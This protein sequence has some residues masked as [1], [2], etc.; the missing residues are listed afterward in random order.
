VSTARDWSRWLAAVTGVVMSL[1]RMAS[2]DYLVG[3]VAAGDGRE[4]STGSALTRYYAA[5]GYPP[6]TWLGTGLT[7]LGVGE[8]VG[9]E[10]TEEQ[11]RALFEDARSPF[12]GTP[13]GRPP[14]TYPTRQERIA[15]R[16]GALPE[17]MTAQDRAATVEKILAEEQDTKT[18][19]AVAG[20]D[21]TFSVPKSVSALWALGDHPL[22][23][24]LYLAHRAA[25]TAT[26][27]LV[28]A[29]ALFTRTGARGARRVRTGGMIAAA[30]DHWDSRKGDPQLHTH[31]TVANRVQGPDG[32][33]RTLDSAVLHRAVVAYSETYN[34]LLADEVTRR[35]GLGWELRERGGRGRRPARELAGVSD[36]LIAAFSQRSA[37]IEAAV[38]TAIDRTVQT[39]GRHPS[40]RSLNRIRQHIT[41]TTRD[42]KKAVSL[43]AAVENWQE[44]ARAVLGT[45]PTQWARTL[46]GGTAGPAR[47]LRGV[48]VPDLLV[49]QAAARVVDAVAGSRATWTKWNLTAETM[50]RITASGWQF[51]SNA[52]AVAVR[53]RI[54]TAAQELSASLIPGELA[55]VPDAFRDPDGASQF[56]RPAIFTS[57]RVLAAEDALLTLAADRSG[58]TVQQEQAQRVAAERLPGRGYALSTEDQA[59]AAVSIATSG[60]VVDVLVGPAGTGKT[61]SMAGVRAMWEAEYGPGSV[62]G[63]A[64]SAKAAQV[65]AADLGI[66]TDNT[67]QWAAQQRLQPD[68]EKRITTLSRRR[69]RALRGGH[70]TRKLDAALTDARGEVDR[71]RLRP[72]Q[73]LIVDEAGM[74][75]T[76]ALA[77]LAQHAR[78]AGAKLLLVGDPCQLSAVETGGAFGLLAAARSDTPTL[79]VVR[80]FVE[81]DG[82]RRTWE[83]HAAAGL[84]TGDQSAASE[85]VHRGRVRGGDRDTM[86][87][88]AYTA[89]LDNTRTGAKSLLIAADSDTVRELN[90]RA[91]ADLVTAGT[92]DDTST[93][94]LHDGLTAGRGDRVV[95][96]EID[97]YLTDGTQPTNSGTTA[98]AASG[99]RADG[100][101][102]NG[103]QWVVD[104]ARRDGSLAVRLLDGDGRPGATAVTLPAGY[105]RRHV[106]LAYAT[107]VHRAQGMTT[108]TAHVLADAATTREA[109]Y[110]AMT[111]GRHHN[112]AYLVLDPPAHR[113]LD[114]PLT[115]S[116]ADSEQP[117]RGEVLNAIATT[118]SG[119]TSAH[120]A[121]RV[122]QDRAGSIAQLANEAETIAAYAHDLA[123]TDL[124]IN[125]LGDT[126]TINALLDDKH[127]GQVVT[128][129]R[130][131]YAAG[132]DVPTVLPRLAAPL[133][134]TGTL[135]ATRLAEAIRTHTAT[136][137]RHHPQSRRLVGGLLPDATPGLA[138]PPLLQALRERYQLI[139]TR[140]DAVLDRD[141]AEH[142]PWVHALPP[143]GAEA[144]QWRATARL[145][146]AYRDRWDITTADPLGP[147]PDGS[148]SYAQQADH[149][150]ATAALTALRQRQASHST[151]PVL[152]AQRSP[153]GRDL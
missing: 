121:I 89:W 85:Y 120:E 136:T 49:E 83:E 67:A 96:R 75:G 103:Q 3:H 110:V 57:A 81:P 125:V 72:G 134:S 135:T 69:D 101:V 25:M 144:T 105:V 13:M 78:S 14:V 53:D 131:A 12:G 70:D 10:V 152:P 26:L 109:F 107:T 32:D 123:A 55:A 31:V 119:Q 17:S 141:L 4:S 61:T 82:T 41:L 140:A 108:D 23:E 56:A 86:T 52:D 35:T 8:R 146:A 113:H 128:A 92:V 139:E 64:P 6:G 43:S 132:T 153:A 127:F 112:Q 2:V 118:T 40:P 90:Q 36:A 149:R 62:I 147:G 16:I 143:T 28:E 114:H 88:A 116:A 63:L 29:E 151:A 60:R 102:R 58:P 79:S 117:T 65:L 11:L 100:F 59:P 138:D 142:T 91:R 99:R 93:V 68:R 97:R 19:A 50:R 21:L 24:Q 80:R 98:A 129:I 133:Q 45:D 46:A 73:L 33:W 66:V 30:F 1:S 22:Q 148:A 39:T 126:P 18:R 95:T 77:E 44:T 84:R 54:V 115:T 5:E 15:R 42:R 47:M 111:R 145:I 9:A 76:F 106:E 74:A 34:Q 38:D 37:D 20:F 130:H 87:A 71:W 150:R 48:D 7:A 51:T 27:E 94:I 124:L 122:E 137:T 104:R